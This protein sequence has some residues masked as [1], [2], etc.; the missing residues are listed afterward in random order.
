M[1][2]LMNAT[3]T[4]ESHESV[5]FQ[6]ELKTYPTCHSWII[7]AHVSLRNLKKQW[8]MLNRRKEH[9]NL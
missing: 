1:I 4:Q 3:A 8:K 2:M 9:D 6:P 5:L 7:T